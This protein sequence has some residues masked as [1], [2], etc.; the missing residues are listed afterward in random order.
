MNLN[1]IFEKHY[2]ELTQEERNLITTTD[3]NSAKNLKFETLADF[4]EWAEE[5]I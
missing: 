1:E 2:E 5:L 4:K 3:Y